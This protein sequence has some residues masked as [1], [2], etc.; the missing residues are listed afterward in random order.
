MDAV[1]KQ[2]RTIVDQVSAAIELVLGVILIAGALVLIAGVQ[3]S[4]DSR[5]QESAILRAVGAKRSLILGGLLIEFAT[6]GLFAGL[7]ACVAAEVSVAIL[8]NTVLDMSYSPSPAVWP[9]G[10]GVG[11]VMIGGLGVFSCRK[12][13]SSPPLAVLREL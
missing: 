6:L 3:S 2:I 11:V 12:V 5:M 4:V 7:L 13:V 8:Q 1:I 10:I 9:L